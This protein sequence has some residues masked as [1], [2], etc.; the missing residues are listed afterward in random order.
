MF[1][2]RTAD[3]AAARYIGMPFPGLP[4]RTAGPIDTDSPIGT[5]ARPVFPRTATS[6]VGLETATP[7][8]ATHPT[9]TRPRATR[10]TPASHRAAYQRPVSRVDASSVP[11]APP[12]TLAPVPSDGGT[13][14]C[15][16]IPRSGTGNPSSRVG[17]VPYRLKSMRR[18]RGMPR[19]GG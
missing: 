12:R 8:P 16:A 1:P 14:T 17:T 13:A 11:S 4:T 2:N 9:T 5:A 7:S 10:H 6:S 3:T 15:V 19:V 18:K